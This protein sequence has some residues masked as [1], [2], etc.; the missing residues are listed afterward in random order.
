M[1]T[2]WLAIITLSL[3]SFSSQS[4]PWESFSQPNRL[5]PAAI[6]SYANGCLLGAEALPLNGYGYQ[7]LRSQNKRYYAHP[8]TVAFIE[9]LSAQA[10]QDL[11]THL[12]IGDM[13]LPQGG[14]FS[15]GHTSHQTGLDVDIWFRLADT[16]L[17]AS[18]LRLPKA[19]SLVDMSAYRL[20]SRNWDKRHFS[21]IKMAAKDDEVA[22]IFVHPLIKEKL[23]SLEGDDRRWL[24][25]IR[26]WWGHNYHMHV[27]LRC[28]NGETN[29]IDQSLPPQGDGC[30]MEVA[31]WRPKP[32]VK[33]YRAK[34]NDEKSQ[35]SIAKVKPKVK[36][37]LPQ[38]CAQLVE[39][40][41]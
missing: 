39:Q 40:T 8:D 6:G 20:I 21:L 1:K 23:C 2:T 3:A 33:T 19:K 30:G 27:R 14:R 4:S 22:R 17:S 18:T 25:K 15:S 9:R 10:R 7:V 13:S 36:K 5:S 26:P 11:Q 37:I 12:L 38:Q 35:L 41:H 16:K 29:C 34:A 32:E 31:S 24:R 28:P